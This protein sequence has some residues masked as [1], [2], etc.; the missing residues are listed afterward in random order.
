MVGSI[1]E[2][3]EKLEFKV[4]LRLGVLQDTEC[5]NHFYRVGHKDPDTL[6]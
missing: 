1:I 2:A 3:N 4:E 5:E 6:F